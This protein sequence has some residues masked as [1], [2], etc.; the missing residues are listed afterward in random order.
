MTILYQE[1]L[2]SHKAYCNYTLQYNIFSYGCLWDIAW[3]FMET[4]R[5]PE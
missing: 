1:G 5:F 4:F 3:F 2:L